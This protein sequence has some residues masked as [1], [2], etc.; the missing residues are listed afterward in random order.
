MSTHFSTED[1]D[2]LELTIMMMSLMSSIN[3]EFSFLHFLKHFSL[4]VYI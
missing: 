2:A 1:P 3:V 4:G